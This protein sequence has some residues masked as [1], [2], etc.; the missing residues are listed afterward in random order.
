V[1]VMLLAIIGVMTCV[2][3]L[4]VL[5]QWVRDAKRVK[6]I[7]SRAE[8]RANKGRPSARAGVV[9]FQKDAGRGRRM[10]AQSS[11]RAAAAERHFQVSGPGWSALEQDVYER[12]ARSLTGGREACASSGGSATH[13][14][15]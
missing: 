3:Y 7:V 14:A 15:S 12:I 8:N 9:G 10:A 11:L 1:T 4:V 6:N 13:K 2:F 5:I